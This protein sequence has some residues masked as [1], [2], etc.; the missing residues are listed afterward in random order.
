M[1]IC[2]ASLSLQTLSCYLEEL[3]SQ[4]QVSAAKIETTVP[5]V[6]MRWMRRWCPILPLTAQVIWAVRTASLLWQNSAR[7]GYSVCWLLLRAK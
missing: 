6:G 3:T 1:D 2:H 4:H 5:L 7:T